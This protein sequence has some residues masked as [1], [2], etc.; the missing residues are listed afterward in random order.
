M[1]R[2]HRHRIVGE[3]CQSGFCMFLDPDWLHYVGCSYG[4]S[5]SSNEE[6][7]C[8]YGTQSFIPSS[9]KTAPG[10]YPET[11]HQ[12]CV[13]VT[14][15]PSVGLFPWGFP[16]TT[17]KSYV[18]LASP[19]LMNSANCK[20]GA[21]LYWAAQAMQISAVELLLALCS[22]SRFHSRCLGAVCTSPASWVEPGIR[23]IVTTAECHTAETVICLAIKLYTF[24]KKL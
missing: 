1:W 23:T 11:F 24:R 3:G 8:S 21:V 5:Y 16:T 15:L 19:N 18:I 2:D 17:K 12:I 4:C 20:E 10:P 22:V 13:F 6:V 14:C 7:P 9:Q